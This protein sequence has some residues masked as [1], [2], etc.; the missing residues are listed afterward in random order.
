MEIADRATPAE[1]H[2]LA[3]AEQRDAELK[4]RL[5][6]DPDFR[7]AYLAE[8]IASLAFEGIEVS[9]EEAERALDAAFSVP[10]PTARA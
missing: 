1:T 5:Q 3:I 7:A 9:P 10:L 4:R 8:A 2:R 6:S